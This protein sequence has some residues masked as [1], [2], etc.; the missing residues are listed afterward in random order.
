M[1]KLSFVM[2][3]LVGFMLMTG[4]QKEE[5]LPDPTPD[6]TVVDPTVVEPTI[7]EPTLTLKTGEGYLTEG[8]EITMGETFKIGF[9]C[10][11][12]T[13]GELVVTFMTGE[14]LLIE[15]TKTW[16]GTQSGEFEEILTLDQAGD[17]IM[18]A[19]LTDT[20]DLTDTLTLN[21][22]SIAPFVPIAETHY[23]GTVALNATATALMFSLPLNTEDEMEIIITE[24]QDGTSINATVNYG[25]N[26]YSTMG[27]RDGDQIDF[28]PF[29]YSL[30]FE[31]S[32]VTV[33]LD[34]TGT[35]GEALLSIEGI[36]SGTGNVSF[37]NSPISIPATIEGTVIGDLNE[38]E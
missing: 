24:G 36:L 35:V 16:E 17:I 27:T 32:T 28:E 20:N 9:E 3:A 22:K 15:R 2:F 29:D 38:V 1:K 7:V 12:E 34:L 31:G 6:P 8:D 26:S 11:G 30:S 19:V 10:T 13:L 21:F 33:T 14:T 4:C 25:G 37:P 18:T 23:R 5:P